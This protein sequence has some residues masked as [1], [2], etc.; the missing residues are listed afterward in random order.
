[1]G[2]SN[3]KA[4][5][6]TRPNGLDKASAMLLSCDEESAADVLRLLDEREIQRLTSHVARL[7]SINLENLEEVVEAVK[8][9]PQKTA[10]LL[11]Q[12]MDEA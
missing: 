7:R 12:W 5:R 9:D 3:F 8:M 4:Q 11:R 1:M 2:Y 10:G 6:E